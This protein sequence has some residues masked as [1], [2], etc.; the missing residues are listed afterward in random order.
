M[1]GNTSLINN[2]LMQLQ[3]NMAGEGLGGDNFFL[4]ESNYDLGKLEM[5]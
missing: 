1:V 5:S 4:N 3:G 2:S